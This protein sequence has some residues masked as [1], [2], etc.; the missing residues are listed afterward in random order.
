MDLKSQH[1]FSDQNNDHRKANYSALLRVQK[2]SR[3]LGGEI[4]S[5]TKDLSKV[6]LRIA[7]CFPD[8]YEVGMSHLG[9]KILYSVINSRPELY[10]E[11]V[12]APW[13]DMEELLRQSGD[14]LRTLETATPL[15]EIDLVGFSL[16]YELC[17]TAILQMMELGG[18]PLKS[19]ERRPGDPFVIAGGP[20]MFNPA[21]FAPFF[22]ACVVGDGEEVILEIAEA[23]I[24]W[25][26]QGTGR[27][28]EL[29]EAW[30]KIPGVY[31]P[32]L[33]AAGAAVKKRIAADLDSAPFPTSLV[34]PFCETVHDRI[35]IE[36]TRGCSRGCRFCQAGMLYRPVRE[37][38]P[39]TLL[40]IAREAISQT[41]W[42]ELA[43]LSLSTGDYSCLGPLVKA[44]IDEFKASR[45]SV[46]L[47]SL[48]TDTFDAEIVDYIRKVRQTGLTLA[49]EAGT[50]RLRRIINKGNTEEDLENAVRS[51]FVAGQKKLK[52]YFM[53]GLP[54]ETDEDLDGLIGLIFRSARWAKGG[55]ITASVSTFVPKAHTPFQWAEQM[56]LDETARRQSYIR[57]YFQKGRARVKFH[58]SR[59]SLVEGIIARGDSRVS[60]VILN[61]FRQGA[62]LDAWEENFDFDRWMKACEDLN[63]SLEDFIGP[64]ATDSTL[65]WGF[66]DTGFHPDFLKEEWAKAVR[67]E[68][69]P[70]CRS[71][72]CTGCGVC[73]F[74]TIEPKFAASVPLEGSVGQSKP[75]SEAIRRFRLQYSKLGKMSLL[76]HHD[77]V[78]VFQRAFK[79]AD[80]N[81][82]YSKGFHPHPKLRF[83]PPTA[84]GIESVAELLDFDLMDSPLDENEIIERLKAQLPN[85]LD[86][87]ILQ[88]IT[89]QDQHISSKIKGVTYEIR[90]GADGLVFNF[91][92][93]LTAFKLA[94][95][96]EITK[97]K[98][99]KTKTRDLKQS[100]LDLTEND[101]GFLMTLD[102]DVNNSVHPLEALAAI[103]GISR[104]DAR[105]LNVTKK[106]ILFDRAEGSCHGQ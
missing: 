64:R 69:T 97:I 80:L 45:T 90:N 36:V 24:G 49:P 47:P 40:K 92:D 65:P 12:F 19:E 62:R 106:S 44:L 6:E 35:G 5:V 74:E 66:I 10:A 86:P 71:A 3:Y 72:G 8:V 98:K 31:V 53:I 77:I 15:S 101:D 1:L 75:L 59:M 76:G 105:E 37:R 55:A 9:L 94:S 56:S 93:K 54:F 7:L 2:P 26:S 22:D 38:S 103:L 58:N 16:Q 100:I 91:L 23:H 95:T 60:E 63:V 34:V 27:R 46:S 81:L 20:L 42:E 85:G 25:R 82:D 41:G 104:E 73:D 88:E 96:Y 51:A 78:R 4:N 14:R 28:E 70:D 43:L 57:R 89:L 39:Q 29:L 21:P 48:R 52:L 61:V 18:I 83:S 13:A 68:A 84:V 11:R 17:A 32:S 33:H 67:E 79:R 30:K 50:D 102:T 99:G 87:V